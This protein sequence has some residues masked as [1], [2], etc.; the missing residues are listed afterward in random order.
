MVE[1]YK[2]APEVTRKRLWLE[3][4]QDVMARNRKVVGGD[5][6]Q[7]I[8]VPMEGAKG[9]MPAPATAIVPDMVSPMVNV[10]EDSGVRTGR[11]GREE[12]TR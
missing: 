7:L 11:T 12:V 8:Y 5:S 1:Q 3:T 2:A 10:T 9:A 6:R 4:L